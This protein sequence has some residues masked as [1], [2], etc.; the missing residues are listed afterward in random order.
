MPVA[1]AGADEYLPAARAC[2][3]QLD[4]LRPP[5]EGNADRVAAILK[6]GFASLDRADAALQREI[7]AL[8]PD[9]K[10]LRGTA[11]KR[12]AADLARLRSAACRVALVR[13]DLYK[14]AAAALPAGHAARDACIA[15]ALGVY[16]SLR[17]AYHDIAPGLMGYLG[18]AAVQRLA[19]DAAAARA[20]VQTVLQIPDDPKAPVVA[21]LKRLAMLED[22]EAQLLADPAKAVAAAEALRAGK[23]YKDRPEWQARA[24]YVSARAL[25]AQAEAL[26]AD[27]PDAPRRADLLRRA[28]AL[29]RRDGVAA[30]APAYD[31]LA[32]LVHI[33]ILSG[34]PLL[35]RDELLGWADLLSAAG[36]DE[37]VTFYDRARDLSGEPLGHRQLLAYVALAMRQGRWP[38]VADACDRLLQDLPAADPDRPAAL[39]WRAAALVKVLGAAE[40]DRRRDLAPRAAAALDAV[41]ESTAPAPVRRDALRQWV[42]AEGERRGLAA[43]VDRLDAHPDLVAGDPYLVYCRAAG[44]Y[45]RTADQWSEGALAEAEAKVRARGIAA[46]LGK[47]GPVAAAAGD[48]GVAARGALLRATILARPPVRDADGALAVLRAEDAAL[49]ADPVVAGAAAWARVEVLLDLGLIEEAFKA[50]AEVPE[51]FGEGSPVARL[52]LAE[53]LAARYPDIAAAGRDEV[54]RRVLGLCDAAMAQAAGDDGSAAVT[55]RAARSLL[56][57]GAAADARRVLEK[58]LVSEKVRG[59]PRRL[60]ECSLLMAEAYRRGGQLNQAAGLLDELAARFPKSLEVHL[61]RGRCRMDLARPARAAESFRAARDL[62]RPGREDWCRATLAL[63]EALAAG[64]HAADAGDILRVAEALYPDFGSPE[65]RGQMRRL[66]R[67]L[68]TQTPGDAVRPPQP[69]G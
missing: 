41:V 48:R 56:G 14:S 39:Q 63:G 1:A 4:M 43:C 34:A 30:A 46:D 8:A 38:D 62:A 33:E 31:R 26:A 32:A 51:G 66:R 18:E 9:K 36:R 10:P 52:R 5:A 12:L 58:A 25:A 20:V 59:D 2:V 65:L 45:Q 40:A 28:A 64:D 54:Q 68:E 27:G 13:G 69:K 21:E 3:G 61:S 22:L 50:L 49:K 44:A 55:V 60:E 24:D 37:A 47:L 23:A 42:A 53:A 19:G 15:D 11:D 29:L 7:E 16:R 67:R 35:A 17:V 6:K 57:V